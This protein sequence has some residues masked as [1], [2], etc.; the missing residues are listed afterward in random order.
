MNTIAI[1]LVVGLILFTIA[2]SIFSRR[3]T[4]TTA[5]FY[6][7]GRKVGSF[8]NASAISGDYLSAASFLGVAGAVYASGLDGVWY[9]AGFAGGFMVVVL[10]IASALRRFGEYTV[11]DFAFGRFGSNRIRLIT[12]L[13]VLLTSLFY[14]APQMFG[15]GTTW[16]VLVGKGIFGMD[17]YT[18]G[19]VVVTAIMAFYVGVGGMKGTTLNQIFQFWWL[20]FAMIMIVVFAFG[21]GFNYPQALADA[22]KTPIVNTKSM[23]VADLTKPD[24]K[25]GKTPYDA[26]ATIMTP[27][28]MA[29]VDEVI[30]AGDTKA[31]VAV[32]LPS[33]N[34]LHELRDQLFNEPGHRYNSFDQFSMVLALVLGTAGLPHILNR[35]YTNPSGAAA[36]RSTFWVL[37]FIGTFYILAPIA[38]LAGIGFIK[39]YL[40]NGG[41]IAAA[42]VHGLLV[43]PDQIMPTLAEILGGQWLMGIVAAGA[44]AA[45]FSTIGGLL[46]AAASAIGHDVFEKYIDPNASERKRVIVG[47]SAV[48][49]FALL[50]MGIGLAI[51]KFGLDQAYPALIAMMVTWAF[52]V[53]GSAFVPMLL[54]GIWWKGTT[55][56][57]ATA[58]IFVGLFGAIGI[59]LMNILQTLGVIGKD[60][61]IGFLGSLT[62]PVLFTFPLSLLTIIIVSKL[63]GELPK[64]V[65]QIWMRI[66]GTAN[67]RHE[68][69][70]GLDKVGTMFAKK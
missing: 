68:K 43:K 48:L 30:A 63:D 34:K 5:D 2:L 56:R 58:G 29:K 15:A 12:V 37:V 69:Q 65:D 45:M 26:A 64:N 17:P 60:G 6:L 38:G 25:T 10:F 52:A 31:K 28:E 18:S 62:F 13:A 47:K 50:A 39:D 41:T 44:F 24:A 14:M 1:V 51:P 53:G 3:F 23:T 22:S 33:K 42:N 20:M 66:H 36:R 67:E 19:V 59:I 11:A 4:R 55:E 21:N 40:A 35:Y 70:H 49:F 7:A 16:S 9:A 8:S 27:A 46:I 57:G 61:I 32:A 54:T